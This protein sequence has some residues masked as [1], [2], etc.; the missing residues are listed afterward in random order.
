MSGARYLI[1]NADD[2]GL[3]AGVNR[4][5]IEAH[6][7]GIV[8]SASL[9]VRCPAAGEAAA[10][11]RSRRGL[12][13]GLHVDLG[14]WAYRD[15][16]WVRLYEVV[17]ADDRAA[18]EREVGRQLDCFRDLAGRDPTHLDSHQHVHREEPVRSVLAALAGRL[19]VPLRHYSPAVRYCGDFYGQAAKG[20]PFPEGIAVE[21]LV[22]LLTGMPPGTTEMGCHPGYGEGLD[23]MYVYER[24]EEVRT[25]CDPRVR[26]ALSAGQIR[27]VSFADLARDPAT[28]DTPP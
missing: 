15:E 1:V 12:S 3:S 10:Y 13:L 6:E 23:S 28:P 11:G 14:E 18:V 26:G 20:W 21:G 2:F 22:R 9:M 7:R 19:G 4:G 17:P 24:A 27:L 8:T 5:I 25:L 16:S